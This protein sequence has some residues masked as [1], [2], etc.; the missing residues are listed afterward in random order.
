MRG[1]RSTGG[2]QGAEQTERLEGVQ[3]ISRDGGN[4]PAGVYNPLR[5]GS[6]LEHTILKHY[7]MGITSEQ[8]SVLLKG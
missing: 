1:G 5:R 3:E 4:F 7:R 2:L 6:V 8:Q